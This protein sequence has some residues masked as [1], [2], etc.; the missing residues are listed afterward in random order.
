LYG[1]ARGLA[2]TGAGASYR[3]YTLDPT[4]G[5]ATLVSPPDGI[6]TQFVDGGYFAFD[7]ATDQIRLVGGNWTNLRVSPVTGT[8]IATDSPFSESGGHADVVDLAYAPVAP[9]ASDATL[10]GIELAPTADNSSYTDQWIRVGSLN[11]SPDSAE[12]GLVTIIGPMGIDGNFGTGLAFI[13]GADGIPSTAFTVLDSIF[14]GEGPLLVSIDVTTGTTTTLGRILN[15][16]GNNNQPIVAL[17]AVPPDTFNPRGGQQLSP[18]SIQ[19]LPPAPQNPGSPT[20]PPATPVTALTPSQQFV[21]QVFQS[22]L[23][24]N[25]DKYSLTVLA[26][27]IDQGAIS[28]FQLVMAIEKSPEYLGRA[29]N[30]IYQSVLKRAADSAGQQAGALFLEAGGTQDELRVLLFG[31]PEYYQKAGGNDPAFLA[32]LFQDVTGQSIDPGSLNTLENL[33]NAGTPRAS[34]ARMFL[35]AVGSLHRP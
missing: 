16:I 26:G 35:L 13:S 6:P 3:L 2:P 19:P 24:R 21:S 7:P 5:V 29:V 30:H 25:P 32:A 27:F 22:L 14:A 4:T 15:P 9:G 17:D 33:V 28:Q 10:F 1:L 34:V 20:P 23:G 18:P 12:S 8:E 11:G 31:S